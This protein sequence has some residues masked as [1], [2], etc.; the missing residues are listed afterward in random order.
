MRPPDVQRPPAGPAGEQ[1]TAGWADR[2][3][4]SYTE[5]RVIW[6]RADW[7]PTTG[8]KHRTFTR[9]TDLERFVHQRLGGRDRPELSPISVLRISRRHV[10]PWRDT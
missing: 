4:G 10:G 1:N 7:G 5:W 9:R 6:R 2:Q 3:A 8:N